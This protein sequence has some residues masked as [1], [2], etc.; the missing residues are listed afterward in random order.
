M[1]FFQDVDEGVPA[2][3][4]GDVLVADVGEEVI[5][6]FV[7]VVGA[8]GSLGV[9]MNEVWPREAVIEEDNEAFP[10]LFSDGFEEVFGGEGKVKMVVFGDFDREA[11][12][13]GFN[14]GG[15]LG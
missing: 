2:D 4:A 3:V 13:N 12:K 8:G 7:F 6:L 11:V 5:V 15:G 10:I 1:V 14:F 9:V